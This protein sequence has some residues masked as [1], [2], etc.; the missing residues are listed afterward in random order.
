LEIHKEISNCG[1]VTKGT[2]R[3]FVCVIFFWKERK[4][5]SDVVSRD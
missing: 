2:R 5:G 4:E 1:H 3:V